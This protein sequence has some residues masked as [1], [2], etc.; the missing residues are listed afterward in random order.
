LKTIRRMRRRG[1]DGV[2]L[3]E[4]YRGLQEAVASNAAVRELYVAPSL[5]LG[6]AEGRLVAA[7]EAAGADVFELS[8]DAFRSVAARRRP[9]GLL[10]L[11]ERFATSIEQLRLPREPFVLVAEGVERPGNLGT[12]MRTACGAGVDALIVCDARTDVFH[13]EA[14]QGSVGALFHLPLV[15]STAGRAIEWLRMRGIRM[16]AATPTAERR[17]WEDDWSGPFA[18]VVGSE[19]HGVSRKSL[20]EADALVRIPMAAGVDSL[21]VAVATGVVL[22][23]AARQRTVTPGARSPVAQARDPQTTSAVRS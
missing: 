16:V 1:G 19:R 20:A 11:V 22:F 18:L 4:G 15:E 8:G 9:D 6:N 14:V 2:F 13:P 17:Y 7:A 23:E 21:N 5:F 3:V 10:A 12:I